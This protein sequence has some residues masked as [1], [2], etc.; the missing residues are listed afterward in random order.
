MA[1][2]IDQKYGVITGPMKDNEIRICRLRD[3][4]A[5]EDTW[6]MSREQAAQI[7]SEL[8]HAIGVEFCEHGIHDGEW[9][10]SCNSEYKRARL[11][12]D[13]WSGR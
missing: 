9:C 13:P 8:T 7:V 10:P 2:F 6:A 12:T 1:M 3:N 11:E 4:G 5:I